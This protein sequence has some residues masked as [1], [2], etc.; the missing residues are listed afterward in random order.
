[1]TAPTREAP[2]R[3]L[4]VDDDPL[5][6]SAL[7]LMLGGQHDIEIVGEA[8][9]GREGVVAAGTLRPDVILMDT[10]SPTRPG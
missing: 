1:M 4:V 5:V 7:G 3:V 10:R 8:A 9:D 6:R 2:V